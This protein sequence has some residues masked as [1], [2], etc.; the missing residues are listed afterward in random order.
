[1]PIRIKPKIDL[2]PCVLTLKSI[3]G[4]TELVSNEFPHATF[5]ADDYIWEI[6]DEKRIPF[7]QEISRRQKLDEFLVIVKLSDANTRSKK[8]PRVEEMKIVFNKEEATVT[9]N[10]HPNQENWIEHFLTDLK[11]HILSPS[12][13]QRMAIL[14][15]TGNIST[16]F[17]AFIVSLTTI[18]LDGETDSTKYPYSRIVIKEN[19]PNPFVENIKAN[20]VSNVIWVLIGAIL[21]LITQW[22]FRTYGVDLNPF[23]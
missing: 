16:L 15:R 19:P 17:P 7:I 21:L 5:C 12:L 8:A 2:G 22:I 23:N 4:I 18:S 20:M 11:K 3:E 13:S 1:M 9:C 14:Y 10:A 6:F